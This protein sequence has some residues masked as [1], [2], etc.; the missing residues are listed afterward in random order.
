M[1][2]KEKVGLHKKMC[3]KIKYLLYYILYIIYYILYIIYVVVCK[4]KI[5]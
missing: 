4:N 5:S 3:K 2:I 1:F